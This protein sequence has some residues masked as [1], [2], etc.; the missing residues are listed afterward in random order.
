MTQMTQ[1]FWERG[2]WLYLHGIWLYRQ[3]RLRTGMVG[4]LPSRF[5]FV[6]CHLCNLRNLRTKEEL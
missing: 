4:C 5:L 3:G 1:I 6:F 2:I